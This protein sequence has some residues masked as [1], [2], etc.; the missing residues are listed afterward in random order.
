[1]I[2]RLLISL[3]VFSSLNV[4][5]YAWGLPFST[6]E[7][8][9]FELKVRSLMKQDLSI[10]IASALEKK[11]HEEG[12]SGDQ[13]YATL[14]AIAFKLSKLST[15][16]TNIPLQDR[17]RLAMIMI[18]KF[19]AYALISADRINSPKY[20]KEVFI[21]RIIFNLGSTHEVS[22]WINQ[23]E[24]ELS[25]A[26]ERER[27]LAE[28]AEQFDWPYQSW[29]AENFRVQTV[30]R[31]FT[32]Y[33]LQI[34]RRL[35]SLKSGLVNKKVV[36]KDPGAYS[37]KSIIDRSELYG[38]WNNS[39]INAYISKIVHSVYFNLISDDQK[40]ELLSAYW[41]LKPIRRSHLAPS[42]GQEID[43][44]YF[45]IGS[46][47]ER[48]ESLGDFIKTY[49]TSDNKELARFEKLHAIAQT[50]VSILTR[51]EGSKGLDHLISKSPS[52]LSTLIPDANLRGLI[53]D[54]AVTA[55]N[56]PKKNRV[57]GMGI[58]FI[59]KASISCVR[60]MVRVQE[61]V[62][63]KMLRK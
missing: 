26:S 32:N 57:M 5:L 27:L 31:R 22:G 30:E 28:I 3:V 25:S 37:I 55:R 8:P 11:A 61:F 13:N 21:D 14:W 29:P 52:E 4:S 12:D 9:S 46:S 7:T 56:L 53:K 1:M 15:P 33:E 34:E 18:K 59:D 60:A 62:H 48:F 36:A 6:G 17:T 50:Y 16:L 43:Y 19:G 47:K 20:F 41:V 63:K 54:Y 42:Y 44:P 38:G 51:I 23:V 24:T 45:I 2:K 39:L 10:L 40:L 35:T 49:R 58:R